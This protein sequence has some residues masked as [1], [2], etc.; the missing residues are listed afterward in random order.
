MLTAVGPNQKSSQ[1]LIKHRLTDGDGE[2][3]REQFLQ[4]ILVLF[5]FLSSLFFHLVLKEEMKSLN[6][7]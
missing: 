2:V 6:E 1:A 3:Y 4:K 7:D 5:S